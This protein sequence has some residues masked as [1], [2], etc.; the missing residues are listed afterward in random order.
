M[1]AAVSDILKSRRQ[2]PEGLKK[3]ALISIAVHTVAVALLAFLPRILPTSS[4]PP[5]IVMSISLGGTP[6]PRTGGTQM[7]GGRAIQAARPATDPAIARSDLPTPP[8]QPKMTQPDPRQ[9]PRTPPKVTATSKDPKGTERG[10]GFE[11]R[12][13]TARAET[14]ARGQGFGLS[15]GGGGG[16]GV[17]LDVSNFCCP[18]YIIDMLERIRKNWNRQQ[19]ATGVVLMKYTIQRSGEITDVEVEAS[20]RNP[21]LDLA[22]QRAL[23]TTRAL[24][25]LPAAF[26]ERQLTVHATFEYVR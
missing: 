3:M 13:G 11:T 8:P 10:R 18:E 21:V 15:S 26:P 5:R 22:A 4:A 12:V 14:G 20:S 2:E 19:D 1:Q 25:P 16:D 17:R 9:K 6:G 7:I 23:I 24:A